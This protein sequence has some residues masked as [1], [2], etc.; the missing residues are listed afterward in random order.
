MATQQRRMNQ[1]KR[2]EIWGVT[3]RAELKSFF[4]A[5]TDREPKFGLFAGEGVVSEAAL[6]VD[7]SNSG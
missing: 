6:V 5:E 7:I 2:S 3:D 1:S 4:K